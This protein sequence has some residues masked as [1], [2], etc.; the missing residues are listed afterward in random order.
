[1][2]EGNRQ[3]LFSSFLQGEHM[4]L[5]IVGLGL[6][7]AV[8]V[9]QPAYAAIP[10]VGSADYTLAPNADGGEEKI[11]S[12][13][14]YDFANGV[15]LIQAVHQ[16]SADRFTVGDTFRGFYQSYVNAHLLGGVS[17]DNSPTKL[18]K[19]GTLQGDLGYE[20]TIIASFT[21]T[22]TGVDANSPGNSGFFS[23]T[24]GTSSLNFDT[25]PNY[26]FIGDSGFTDGTSIITGSVVGGSGSFLSPFGTGF[27]DITLNIA[28][29]GFDAN[30]YNPPTIN[31]G[32]GIF[33]L[34]INNTGTGPS[35]G[36][37]T[38]LG[39][40]GGQLLEADGN[41]FLFAVPEPLSLLLVGSAAI[42]LVV[43]RRRG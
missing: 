1:M 21:S 22:V 9:C 29:S 32:D 35:A 24:N 16:A 28:P 10:W 18:D 13:D 2:A 23:V 8:T 38:V 34:R 40:S 27:S 17:A 25:N 36:V 12:F 7:A 41:L 30:V 11:S 19:N 4:R 26:S 6:V 31:G 3:S 42:G 43:L 5:T 15:A 37:T 39:K 20:L 14:N 33:T